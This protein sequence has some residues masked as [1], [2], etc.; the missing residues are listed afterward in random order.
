MKNQSALPK[1]TKTASGK[2]HATVNYYTAEGKRSSRSFTNADKSR[3]VLDILAFQAEEKKAERMTLGDAIDKYISIKSAVLSPSTIR[4]YKSMR[5]TIYPDLMDVYIDQLN[6]EKMQ[7]AVNTQAMTATPKTVR[8]H[9]G[10]VTAALAVYRPDFNPSVRLPQKKPDKIC[11]PTTAEIRAL[12]NAAKGT[13]MEL[14]VIVA[15]T[16]GLRRSEL[17]ALT[18]DDI[19]TERGVICITKALVNTDDHSY[20]EKAPKTATSAREVRP[21]PWVM[22]KLNEA[23]NGPLHDGRLFIPPDHVSHRFQKLC[24]K[25]GVSQF[26]FHDLRHYA[27]SAMLGQGFPKSYAAS[28]LGHDSERMLDLVYGHIMTDVREELEERLITYYEG[29]FA[30]IEH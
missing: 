27:A 14:P 26:R 19:D 11:I 28:I 9:Y 4:A 6:T 3:L 25:A 10:L 2:F 15:A 22:E 18:P 8:N 17:C 13:D 21:F 5:R 24:K 30:G 20:A 12:L 1:I 23:K 16:L 29:V 7:I